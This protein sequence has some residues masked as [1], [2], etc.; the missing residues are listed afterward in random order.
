MSKNWDKLNKELKEFTEKQRKEEEDRK[1]SEE[2]ETKRWV[3]KAKQRKKRLE[4]FRRKQE[5]EEEAKMR[6]K[7]GK[8]NKEKIIIDIKR[9]TKK[10]KHEQSIRDQREKDHLKGP[11]EERLIKRTDPHITSHGWG[12]SGDAIRKKGI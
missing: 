4:E 3:S 12:K 8:K 11:A 9:I 1:R 5:E 6:E 7:E 2:E 10:E